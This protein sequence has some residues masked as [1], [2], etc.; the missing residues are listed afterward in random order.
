MNLIKTKS[1]AFLYYL[2]DIQVQEKY[3]LPVE[4]NHE[5]NSC[6]GAALAVIANPVLNFNRKPTV[7]GPQ[8]KAFIETCLP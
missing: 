3:K 2:Y 6:V 1:N 4:F 5:G 7:E 8:I